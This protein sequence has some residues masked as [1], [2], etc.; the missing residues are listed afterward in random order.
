MTLD[1][2]QAGLGQSPPARRDRPLPGTA[3]YPVPH[4]PNFDFDGT[5]QGAEWIDRFAA[6]AKVVMS[7]EKVRSV[8]THADWSARNIRIVDDR[9]V[10]AYDS[11]ASMTEATAVGQTALTWRS[12]PSRATVRSPTSTSWMPTATPTR[13]PPSTPSTGEPQEPGRSTCLPTSPGASTRFRKG[14]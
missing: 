7:Q 11:V 9:L 8:I 10:A 2:G 6:Q 5:A 14:A 13:K 12:R 3:F 4:S 1:L